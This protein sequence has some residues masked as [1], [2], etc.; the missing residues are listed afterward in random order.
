M[1][2]SRAFLLTGLIAHT[3]LMQGRAVCDPSLNPEWSKN[4]PYF[5]R[6]RWCQEVQRALL[7]EAGP[8]FFQIR[9]PVLFFKANIASG[10]RLSAHSCAFKKVFHGNHKSSQE[11][12]QW[13]NFPQIFFGAA[14]PLP[15]SV[16][17]ATTKE[18]AVLRM[19][20]SSRLARTVSLS[21]PG[22]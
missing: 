21:R 16:R 19:L 18:A 3:V 11:V 7:P 9:S 1:Q 15:I 6:I 22:G 12:K 2:D 13:P 10:F 4:I 20:M 5:K 17:A 14:Q 8:A